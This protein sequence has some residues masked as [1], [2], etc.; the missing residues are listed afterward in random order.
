MT[1]RRATILLHWLTFTLLILLI[2]GGGAW[3]AW[4]FVACALAFSLLAL[5]FG[6]MSGPGP[7]LTG[8]VRA[9]H[10]WMHRAMYIGA[11][12]V[13][14]LTARA[15]WT[16]TPMPDRALMILLAAASL[17]GIFH[18]WRHTALGDGALR[19]ITPRALHGLL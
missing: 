13:A 14:A 19:R 16:G 1:R 7:K 12:G 17:H 5:S 18:L 15:L 2:A 11:A 10:P 3:L 9:A 6:L 4:A 8:A